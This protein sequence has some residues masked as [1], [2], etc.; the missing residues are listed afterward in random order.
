MF[1]EGAVAFI[2]ITWPIAG[3]VCVNTESKIFHREGWRWYGKTKTGSYR[4]EADALEQGY[5]AGENNNPHDGMT[6][7]GG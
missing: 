6:E 4:P 5:R 2:A 3:L 7:E 1:R